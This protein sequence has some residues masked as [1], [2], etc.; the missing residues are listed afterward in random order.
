MK[1]KKLFYNVWVIC[2]WLMAG[3]SE[4]LNLSPIDTI[5][6]ENA[7]NSANDLQLYT[8]SFYRILPDGDA[9]VRGDA[10]S[11]YMVRNTVTSYLTGT[12]T[13]H[14]VGG[15]SWSQLRNIN[16]FLENFDKADIPDEA[17]GHFEGVARFF[18]AW[19]YY[20]KVQKWGG[21]PWYD[22]TLDVSDPDIYKARDSR[23]FV[24][25]KILE[26]L[27]F[28]C[29]NIR[30][31]KDET[32]TMVTKW[33]A[34]GFKSRV[35]LYEGTYRKYHD[36]IGLQTSAEAW[37]IEAVT[38]AEEIMESGKYQ[39]HD[40]DGD[41]SYRNLFIQESVQSDE[42]LLS[43]A[44]SQSMRIFHD[45]NWY[46]T[47]S[48]YGQRLNLIKTFINTYLNRDGSRFTDHEN[49]DELPFWEEVEN[50][51]LRLQ[52]TIRMGDYSREGTPEATD[53]KYSFSGYQPIK[54]TLDSKATD[55][56]AENNNSLPLIRYGEIL[57]NY[58]EAKAEIGGFTSNDWEISIQLLRKRAG[59]VDSSIPTQVDAY[60][61]EHYFPEI[62]DPVLLEI[63][64]ERGIELV[65]EGLRF[66]DLM[67][68][69]QGHLLTMEYDGMYI[70][71]MDELMDVN[72]DG[73]PD[74][75]FVSSIPSNP[76]SGVTYYLI[77]GN[78][79]KLSQGNKGKLLLF[80]NLTRLWEDYQYLY[81]VPY[82]EIVLNR[83]LEQNPQWDN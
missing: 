1:M 45:A 6:P 55:G 62:S 83:T 19:F 54:F 28:A 65:M 23:E 68:W 75:S 5:S 32:G 71:R 35:C 44:G 80:Q 4:E 61:Q 53:F 2:V 22:K 49:Y 17:K 64:R 48:T 26:D 51:D 70:E 27:N 30:S 7:F 14:D 78:Q 41:L 46:F 63:R 72:Q 10:V 47:S 73:F 34:L 3:C 76:E 25:D 40:T 18:R 81:P 42:V 57:L 82:D 13:S 36:E 20:E 69:K 66:Q 56:V 9:I 39:L 21:V 15:W 38:A 24:M 79:F 59:I 8:N 52:Q 74:V 60:L 77:D 29:E 58:A 16:Y 50:R 11:D 33:V 31:L 12:Y 37:L 43:Y 67:R